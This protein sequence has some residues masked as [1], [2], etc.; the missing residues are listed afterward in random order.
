[1]NC[2][3]EEPAVRVSAATLRPARGA[4]VVLADIDFEI[5][6]GC[7]AAIIGPN[8]AG[9][10]TL[11]RT[12]AGLIT[13]DKGVVAIHGSPAR[14]GRTD[15]ALLSQRPTLSP[16]VPCT[17]RRLVEMSR[18]GRSRWGFQLARDDRARAD[19]ALMAVG[20]ETLADRQIQELS[21]GQLQRGLLAR[22]LA[23][24]ATVLLLDEPHA[25]LDQASRTALDELLFGPA[26]A[27]TTVVLTTHN[28]SD[29][30]RFDRVLTV[31]NGKVATT[32]ACSGGHPHRH[33]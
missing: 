20:L 10:S 13:P 31:G 15:L 17:V 3:C 9:K 8:G 5:P 27:G 24:G 2:G 18:L 11:L 16:G 12:L 7:R 19:A 26:L 4:P 28:P 30:G 32:L 25:A 6:R 1:M 14:A 33:A 29:I 22:A 21:G 23:Q